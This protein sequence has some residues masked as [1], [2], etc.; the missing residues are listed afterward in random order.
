MTAH[1]GRHME[2]TA[3]TQDQQ[4]STTGVT[5]HTHPIQQRREYKTQYNPPPQ[6]INMPHISSIDKDL[7]LPTVSHLCTT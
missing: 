3:G 1:R 6:T 5:K 2:K 7:S 4:L